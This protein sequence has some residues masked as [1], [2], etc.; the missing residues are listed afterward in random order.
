MEER[1]EGKSKGNLMEN[2][3]LVK[4][5]LHEDSGEMKVRM[6]GSTVPHEIVGVCEWGRGVVEGVRCSK[7]GQLI[8]RH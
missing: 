2:S 1:L 8:W 7:K 5:S 3:V 4:E 6:E